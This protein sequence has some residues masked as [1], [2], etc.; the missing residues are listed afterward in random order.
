[1][2][3]GAKMDT[4]ASI[5][6]IDDSVFDRFLT[7]EAL[8]QAG[9]QVHEGEDGAK[10]V[11]QFKALNPA[12]VL[13]DVNMPHV[14]GF[15][16]C[17]E[18]RALPGGEH[19]PILMM[20]GLEDVESINRAYE[21]GATDFVTKPLST[22]I[23]VHRVR[24]MLRAL[25]V[26]EELRE[27]EGLLDHAQRLAKLGSWRWDLPTGIVSRSQE[28][29]RILGT[30]ARSQVEPLVELLEAVHDKDR[31]LVR[32][33]YHSVLSAAQG[34]GLEYQIS[35]SG[36]SDRVV[37]EELA[38]ELDANGDVA[39]L[40]G[41][42]QDITERRC[43]EQR[44]R[45]LA[46]YDSVTGLP[47]RMLLKEQV[48]QT[49]AAAARHGRAAALLFLDL[50]HFK[51]IN[52][53]LGHSAGDELLRLVAER[54]A[55][56]VRESDY[57]A[58]QP[59]DGPEGSDVNGYDNPGSATVA[60]LGGDEFVILLSDIQ[61]PEDAA[62]VA[63]RAI[64]SLRLPFRVNENEIFVTGSIGISTFP[65]DG[66][67]NEEL[68]K[69]ADAAMYHAKDHG[70]NCYQFFTESINT[71][72]LERLELESSLR[73]AIER[74][75]FQLYYQPK[76]DLKSGQV[77]GAEALIRWISPERGFVPPDAFIS[78]AEETGLL[79]PIGEW[80][81]REACRQNKE[82]IDAGLPAIRVSVNISAVQCTDERF[83]HTVA[84]GLRD[85]GL[86][87]QLL[88]LE[89]TESL[90]MKNL[91]T[92][93]ALL[94][95]LKALGLQISIDDFGTGHSSLS[96]LKRLP[97]DTIK[98]DRSFIRDIIDDPDDANIV[99]ATITLGH[100]LRLTVVAEGVED[101]HQ[102]E[103]LRARGCDETQ[104]YFFS[105]PLPAEE[106]AMWLDNHR[107]GAKVDYSVDSRTDSR[108]LSRNAGT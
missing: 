10:A 90:L 40:F 69:H 61:R 46:Y 14:D 54:L 55:T 70:R 15:T 19:V 77:V 102:L 37:H 34:R 105:K 27:S 36:E 83:L 26:A 68:L 82:W 8:I 97:I 60:R 33:V 93:V 28:A 74:N 41:T 104:G 12:L 11:S 56:N 65:D 91:E 107:D 16:A 80:V 4:S 88:E 64:E 67:S 23:L 106:F 50:D 21:V 98:I 101:E 103:F 95:R 71:R 5:L 86:C 2:T 81:L 73:K 89:V 22:P 51:R 18:I 1:M 43:T 9:F 85:S 76:V 49:L 108:F 17:S 24:Y 62:V 57:V 78:L 75:E 32:D 6:V 59:S 58:V 30:P 87:A 92:S 72:A 44:I 7:R 48:R 42:V 13:M 79:V 39:R 31:D 66:E 84:D 20:T 25:Q 53:T 38:V 45:H 29:V 100:N 99:E 47:N 63:E 52:D 94:E 3:A 96:Y 35:L